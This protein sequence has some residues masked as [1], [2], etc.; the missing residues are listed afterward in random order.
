MMK[1]AIIFVMLLLFLNSII[2]PNFASAMGQSSTVSDAAGVGLLVGFVV[3]GIVY[4][5]Y[6][7]TPK[8]PKED[9]QENKLTKEKVEER[10]TPS[11]E[12]VLLRW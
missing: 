6:K 9:K 5:Y 1:K 11:G 3:V 2:F 12:L 8:E 4:Y 7:K 10:I